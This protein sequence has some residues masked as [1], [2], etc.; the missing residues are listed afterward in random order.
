[1]FQ[2]QSQKKGKYVNIFPKNQLRIFTLQ[3]QVKLS[4]QKLQIGKL[5]GNLAINDRD[6]YN[7]NDRDKYNLNDRDKY[8]LNNRNKYNLANNFNLQAT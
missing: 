1:M 7:L 4:F 5:F 6:K 8:N 3:S 2:T